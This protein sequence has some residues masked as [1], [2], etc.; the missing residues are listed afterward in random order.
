MRW[1]V[2][3]AV[4]LLLLLQYTIWFGQSGFFAQKRLQAQLLEQKQRVSLI[5]ERNY[6]L[7]AEVVALKTDERALEARARE[8]L[9]LIREGEVFY[10]V[11]TAR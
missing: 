1:L 4:G 7:T 11:P 8:G 10:L 9:G 5:E 2:I 6:M 3:L